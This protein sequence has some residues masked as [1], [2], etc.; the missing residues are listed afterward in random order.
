MN[1][2]IEYLHP[3]SRFA[4]PSCKQTLA[5]IPKFLITSLTPLLSPPMAVAALLEYPRTHM[6][7]SDHMAKATRAPSALTRV[8]MVV[9]IRASFA[10]GNRMLVGAGSHGCSPSSQ[11]SS[12]RVDCA[13]SDGGEAAT[14]GLERAK[15]IDSCRRCV[16]SNGL[17]Q[18]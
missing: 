2:V 9:L 13:V 5:A 7:P 3:A 15:S 11:T 16:E 8:E 14:A 10:I 18:A 6:V 17:A 12:V 4:C 1:L